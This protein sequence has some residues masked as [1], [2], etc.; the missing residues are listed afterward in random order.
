MSEE[1]LSVSMTL[2]A[3]FA[4]DVVEHRVPAVEAEAERLQQRVLPL[5]ELPED[6]ARGWQ[7]LANLP[8]VAIF[9]PMFASKSSCNLQ[10]NLIY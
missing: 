3:L 7:M 1:D 9:E 8:G 4:G 10:D 6:L 5:R 2:A